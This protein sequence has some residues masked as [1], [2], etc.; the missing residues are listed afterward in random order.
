MA[1]DPDDDD[2]DNDVSI[3]QQIVNAIYDNDM[4]NLRML[5][6]EDADL[7]KLAAYGKKGNEKVTPLHIAMQT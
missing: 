3:E 6:L 2:K 5:L 1:Y 4:D 7:N